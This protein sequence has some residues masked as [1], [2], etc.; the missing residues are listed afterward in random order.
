MP[1]AVWIMLGSPLVLGDLIRG[2]TL[3]A[4]FRSAYGHDETYL[5]RMRRQ[6]HRNRAATAFRSWILRQAAASTAVN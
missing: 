3:T 2:N 6:S 5:L 1:R 4:P